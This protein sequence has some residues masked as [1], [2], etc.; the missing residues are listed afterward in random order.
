MAKPKL[1]SRAA[2]LGTQVARD[3]G[4]QGA[5]DVGTPRG[6]LGASRCSFA[7]HPRHTSRS[8]RQDAKLAVQICNILTRSP[9]APDPQQT[10]NKNL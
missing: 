3:G 5:A 8:R 4:S 9:L 1:G 10:V 6:R 7:R 2:R